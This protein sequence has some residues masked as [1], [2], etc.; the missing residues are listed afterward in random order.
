MLQYSV[1]ER[2]SVSCKVQP[3][4]PKAA[5]HQHNG[6]WCRKKKKVIKKTPNP[7]FTVRKEFQIFANFNSYIHGQWSAA[8][9]NKTFVQMYDW[10]LNIYHHFSSLFLSVLCILFVVIFAKS[11][12]DLCTCLVLISEWAVSVNSG[13][14]IEL[15]LPVL[16]RVT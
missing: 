12:D 8:S 9:S 1:V 13:S 7:I 10:Y 14:L 2:S 6:I 16:V 5:C 3:V 4:L 15:H 11:C